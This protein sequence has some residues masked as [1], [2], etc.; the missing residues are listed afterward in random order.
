M[1]NLFR[2][3]LTGYSKKVTYSN[4]TKITYLSNSP[5]SLFN[6]INLLNEIE[7]KLFN[8]GS[9][10]EI[11]SNF[12][13]KPISNFQEIFPIKN[14]QAR[15]KV[16]A[17]FNLENSYYEIQ[18]FAIKSEGHNVSKYIIRKDG[19]I[20]GY[21]FRIYDHGRLTSSIIQ[22]VSKKNGNKAMSEKDEAMWISDTNEVIFIEKFGHTQI[23]LWG[24]F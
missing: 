14:P 7:L 4:N 3:I 9:K 16:T 23:Y 13:N 22:E 20:V 18:R 17:K 12:L 10:S 19:K 11:N 5:F 8:K 15:S 21:I 6:P 1:I 2:K 24:K